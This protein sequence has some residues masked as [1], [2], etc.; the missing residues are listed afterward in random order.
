MDTKVEIKCHNLN[1]VYQKQIRDAIQKIL[2]KAQEDLEKQH[3]KDV[4]TSHSADIPAQKLVCFFENSFQKY[5]DSDKHSNADD[6]VPIERIF[7]NIFDTKIVND[8]EYI[9][10]CIDKFS[11]KIKV[12]RLENSLI[13]FKKVQSN[14][15]FEHEDDYRP[16]KRKRD[17]FSD[18]NASFETEEINDN[19]INDQHKKVKLSNPKPT[20]SVAATSS[21][22]L[23]GGC[24]YMISTV[25][26]SNINLFDD[27]DSDNISK[28]NLR[29]EID[30][31]NDIKPN[32][33]NF[34]T[35][36][37]E[38]EKK[39]NKDDS[40]ASNYT[41][42]PKVSYNL[43]FGLAIGESLGPNNAKLFKSCFNC[44]SFYHG[45]KD[46]TAPKQQETISKN[47]EK[48]KSS[49]SGQPKQRFHSA[50]SDI[51]VEIE[52]KKSC[53]PGA[54]SNDLLF[55]LGAVPD[56]NFLDANVDSFDNSH[57]VLS[58][59]DAHDEFTSKQKDCDRIYEYIPKFVENMYIYGYPPSYIT[60]NSEKK[61]EDVLFSEP[62]LPHEFPILKIYNSQ[63]D[64]SCLSN[65]VDI[66][67]NNPDSSERIDTDKKKKE[68][69]NSEVHSS[70]S[71]DKEILNENVDQID[72]KVSKIRPYTNNF[73]SNQSSYGG[74]N[75][76]YNARSNTRDN[77]ES[78]SRNN[79]RP[80][81]N[82]HYDGI[83]KYNDKLNYETCDYNQNVDFT[84]GNDYESLNSYK[85]SSFYNYPNETRNTENNGNY[86]AVDE[87]FDNHS[88][89]KYKI[90]I[91]TYKRQEYNQ[92][93][94]HD[95]ELEYDDRNYSSKNYNKRSKP[96]NTKYNKNSKYQHDQHYSQHSN[97][98]YG[99]QPRYDYNQNHN[100]SQKPIYEFSKPDD[101]GYSDRNNSQYNKFYSGDTP[102]HIHFGVDAK[103]HKAYDD[104]EINNI[105][106]GLSIAND[107]IQPNFSSKPPSI[108]EE[109]RYFISDQEILE[110]SKN[111]PEYSAI[112]HLEYVT[113]KKSQ[114]KENKPNNDENFEDGEVSSGDDQSETGS[115]KEMDLSD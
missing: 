109:K 31:N 103:S 111:L 38:I 49:E 88:K 7:E 37:T 42:S 4:V 44:G 76:Y 105:N 45:I 15:D 32:H 22:V 53:L 36:N 108:N 94:R 74:R 82:F 90:S 100:N 71:A 72:N 41:N 92:E 39:A 110:D 89:K 93:N 6:G 114:N 78:S 79:N 62:S 57:N 86:R 26:S 10:G 25:G 9:Y 65:Q 106:I 58:S 34:K 55:A 66:T 81:Q 97:Y 113:C 5:V 54:Y 11:D 102:N 115:Q 75:N 40:V 98:D 14:N 70:D 85:K 47:L 83:E 59:L 61:I 80:E 48:F 46:C 17:S 101:Y 96:H 69:H 87:E 68:L 35:Y 20:L 2:L 64:S 33:N 77:F 28:L 50:I 30:T 24:D 60:D 27:I 99:Q 12:E 21:M 23:Y 13:L 52:M 16:V 112:E 56:K 43:E 8:I 104:H 67:L 29:D 95:H 84:N 18:E 91:Q 3:D 63:D 1:S 73:K 107:T 51:N 19:K